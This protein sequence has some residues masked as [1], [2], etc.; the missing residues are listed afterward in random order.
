MGGQTDIGGVGTVSA[1]YYASLGRGMF[2][3]PS[4]GVG[5]FYGNRTVGKDP[6]ALRSSIFGGTGRTGLGLVFYPSARFNVHAGPEAVASFGKS[7]SGVGEGFSSVDAGFN[8]GLS[9]VF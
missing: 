8:V 9:Y 7:S 4:I 1:G 2:L 5:G 6:G 3:K